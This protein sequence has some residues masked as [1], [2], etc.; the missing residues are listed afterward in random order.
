MLFS[1]I[2]R[3]ARADGAKFTSQTERFAAR[4]RGTSRPPERLFVGVAPQMLLGRWR[5]APVFR[6]AQ[7]DPGLGIADVELHSLNDLCVLLIADL[8]AESQL[9]ARSCPLGSTAA[10]DAAGRTRRRLVGGPASERRL[11]HPSCHPL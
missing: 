6:R 8:L 9:A 2:R 3:V 10:R 1:P 11:V 7:V 5:F 4:P